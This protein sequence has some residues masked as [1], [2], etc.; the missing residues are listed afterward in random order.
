MRPA[1]RSL[2]HYSMPSV[3]CQ[4]GVRVYRDA[5]SKV[6]LSTPFS[7]PSGRV[8]TEVGAASFDTPFGHSG[9]SPGGSGY[10]VDQGSEAGRVARVSPSP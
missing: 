4:Y 3:L 9:C 1:P 7:T 8:D 5:L 2:V 6:R 10:E